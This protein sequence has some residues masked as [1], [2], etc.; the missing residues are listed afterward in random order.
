MYCNIPNKSD[1]SNTKHYIEQLQCDVNNQRTKV[2]FDILRL[3]S[4]PFIYQQLTLPYGLELSGEMLLKFF[5]WYLI[6]KSFV[7]DQNWKQCFCW[8]H[9]VYIKWKGV[10]LLPEFKLL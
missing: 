6:S 8:D 1:T 7:S 3:C 2:L 5:N 4:I 9:R 10:P